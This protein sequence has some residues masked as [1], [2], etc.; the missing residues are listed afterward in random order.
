[1]VSFIFK[2][3]DHPERPLASNGVNQILPKLYLATCKLNLIYR[4]GWLVILHCK[5]STSY[6]SLNVYDPAVES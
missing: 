1:M 6:L 2:E 3:H 5:W 4:L